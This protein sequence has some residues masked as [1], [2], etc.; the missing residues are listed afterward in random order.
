MSKTRAIRF[1]DEEERLIKAFLKA[2]PY[3]DFSTLARTSIHQF[4]MNP[5]LVLNPIK[6][7]KITP[8]KKGEVHNATV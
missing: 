3:F 2:N 7:T 5:K 1:S 6:S 8:S 4:I